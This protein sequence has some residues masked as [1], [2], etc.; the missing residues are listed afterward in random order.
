MGKNK[1][2]SIIGNIG[3]GKTTLAL[4]LKNHYKGFKYM[5]ID[6]YRQTLDWLTNEIDMIFVNDVNNAIEAGENIIIETSGVGSISSLINLPPNAIKIKLYC[7]PIECLN[8]IDK[9]SNDATIKTVPPP[10]SGPIQRSVMNI[11]YKLNLI[12]DYETIDTIEN[13]E[14]KVFQ[15]AKQFIS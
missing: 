13:N 6:I 4:Q 12:D 3:S 5:S 8:R 7:N 10:H 2:I 9:R 1:V 14:E 15:M 11:Y